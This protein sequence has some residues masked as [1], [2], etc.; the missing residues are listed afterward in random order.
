MQPNSTPRLA[1]E[2]SC[3]SLA[4]DVCVSPVKVTSCAFASVRPIEGKDYIYINIH[5]A[6][7]EG[8]VI[9]NELI[10]MDAQGQPLMQE[11]KTAKG[12]PKPQR[13]APTGEDK[14]LPG[15]LL[16]EVSTGS[17]TPR[18]QL[19]GPNKVNTEVWGSPLGVSVFAHSIDLLEGIDLVYDSYCGEFRLGKKRI[20]VPQTM[21]QLVT[22]GDGDA[23]MAFDDNDTEF[24]GLKDDNLQEIKEIN[25][26]LRIDAHDQ[27]IQRFVNFLSAKC[28]LGND[29]YKFE[30][31]G[32]KTATEVVSEKSELYQNLCK[33]ELVIAQALDGMCHAIAEICGIREAFDV[34]VNFDDSIIQ[35]SEAK[36]ARIQVML[37]GGQF[38]LKRYLVEYEG[39]SEKDA[40]DIMAEIEEE[41]PEELPV[42]TGPGAD[43][44]ETDP[45]KNAFGAQEQV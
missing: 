10:P 33:N 45:A 24:Y 43:G 11:Q 21:L 26:E 16:P 29:R 17:T 15:G 44:D 22:D 28:G 38:P 36:R 40:E 42:E 27:A 14:L 25:M 34:E 37:S 8:Y 4:H 23:Y 13:V 39:Y 2:L 1:P 30:G 3:S 19:F 7:P 5:Q 32:L 6:T 9:R 18:F 12:K 41:A 20:I 35:D 31:N